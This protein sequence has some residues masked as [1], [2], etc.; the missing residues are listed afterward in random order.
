MWELASQV[1]SASKRSESKVNTWILTVHHMS[2]S[3][4]KVHNFAIFPDK[5]QNYR[6]A[7]PKHNLVAIYVCT[8]YRALRKTLPGL[9]FPFPFLESWLIGS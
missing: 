8:L 5:P 4:Y 9:G 3:L 1:N 2:L 7:F 6:H